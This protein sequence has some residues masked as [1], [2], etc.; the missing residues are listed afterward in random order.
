M[1]RR[2]LLT[3]YLLDLGDRFFLAGLASGGLWVLTESAGVR[4]I[5]LVSLPLVAVPSAEQN[6][7]SSGG[8]VAWP[9]PASPKPL[10]RLPR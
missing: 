3:S 10:E 5:R 2:S 8:S 1:A 4:V 9:R 7:P 6:C